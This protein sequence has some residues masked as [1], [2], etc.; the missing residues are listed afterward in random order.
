LQ[1]HPKHTPRRPSPPP[2]IV[3]IDPSGRASAL[4]RPEGLN[5]KKSGA[6]ISLTDPKKMVT[7]P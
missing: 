1:P 3:G 4:R 5:A 7:P 6:S 2:E